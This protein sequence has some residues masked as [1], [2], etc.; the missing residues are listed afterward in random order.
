MEPQLGS[1]LFL[2]TK[3]HLKHFELLNWAKRRNLSTNGFPRY[4]L[5][6]QVQN[7]T[8]HMQDDRSY[9]VAK[10]WKW[11]YFKSAVL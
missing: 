11:K 9:A 1:T 10:T 7:A 6:F 2:V 8:H 3:D 5:T 4:I